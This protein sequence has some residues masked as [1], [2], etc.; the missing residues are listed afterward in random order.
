[1]TPSSVGISELNLF[2][3][4]AVFPSGIN[5]DPCVG[6]CSSSV[7]AMRSSEAVDFSV[8]PVWG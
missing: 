5:S 8:R 6:L 3:Q 4:E 7:P 1:M 2:K